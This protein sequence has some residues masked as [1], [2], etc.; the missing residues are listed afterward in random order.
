M[1]KHSSHYFHLL[2]TSMICCWHVDQTNKDKKWIHKV[3]RNNHREY[4]TLVLTVCLPRTAKNNE[5]IGFM[6]YILLYSD[7]GS[8]YNITTES[9]HAFCTYNSHVIN[10]CTY[11]HVVE[12]QG[13]FYIWKKKFKTLHRYRQVRARTE[14][15]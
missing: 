1:M 2:R 6:Y 15:L 14:T 13:K 7:S 3:Q 12:P 4:C 8:K 9:V 11:M 10:I 5:P